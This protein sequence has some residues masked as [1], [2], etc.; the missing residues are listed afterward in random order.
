MLYES[1]VARA[2][3]FSSQALFELPDAATWRQRLPE[4]RRQWRE[5]LGLD[6]L[7]ERGDLHATI[8]GRLERDD[9][10]VEKL[11]YQ[12]LPGCRVAANLYLPAHREGR[13]P[14]VLYVCGHSPRAKF[15]YQPHG[16]WFA[17]H[18][19]ACMV[20]DTIWAGECDGLHHGVYHQNRWHWYSQGYTPAGV[21]VW[22]AMRALDYLETRDDI[23]ATRFGITGNSGGGSISW[24]TGAAD[25]RLKAVAPSCQTGTVYQHLRERTLDNHCDCTYWTNTCGWDLADVAATIAPRPLLIAAQ[26]EDVYFRAYAYHDVFER[27][28]RVYRLLGVSERIELVEDGAV[29]GYTPRTR[30]GIFSWFDVH[31]RGGSGAVTDDVDDRDDRDTDLAVYPAMKPPAE[32]RMRDVDRLLIALPKP[33]AITT[34]DAW[35]THQ[36]D[37]LARL[38]ATTLR[39]TLA[40]IQ[41]AMPAVAAYARGTGQGWRYRRYEFDVEPGLRLCAHLATPVGAAATRLL[42]APLAADARLGAVMT[43]FK[44]VDP[45][46]GTALAAVE[47][48]GRG[49]TSIGPGL[50]WSLRRGYPLL[51]Q[52]LP[53]RQVYDL[54]LAVR[55]LRAQLTA[56]AGD[57]GVAVYGRGWDAALAVYAALVDDTIGE[58]VLEQPIATHWDGGPELLAVLKVGDLPH[59]LALACPRPVTFVGEE[60]AAYAWTRS[61]YEACGLGDRVRVQASMA[62]WAGGGQTLGSAS[63]SEDA[64]DVAVMR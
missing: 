45:G 11:H 27:A 1:L 6:P 5:M 30:Q 48:R 35:R 22:A 50:E 51:G 17:R 26:R 61:V 2:A 63:A 24:F 53:E 42:V 52:T 44:D 60:P 41:G 59:N 62:S 8:T 49:N 31:L 32:D 34:G 47:V 7:P 19:Y 14:A 64:G 25:E 21:E 54:L 28:S 9:Y 43:T 57:I 58:L 38:K 36:R 4:R 18:G 10:L 39:P 29:H 23:D 13:L 55:V 15:H 20:L 16:R 37:A 12:P 3:E 46:A 56:G 40:A 33:P